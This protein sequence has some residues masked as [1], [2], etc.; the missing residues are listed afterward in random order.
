MRH[1]FSLSSVVVCAATGQ[2]RSSRM[3]QMGHVHGAVLCFLHILCSKIPLRGVEDFMQLRFG[4]SMRL[5]LRGQLLSRRI[6]GVNG[7][8][9]PLVLGAQLGRHTESHHLHARQQP[10]SGYDHSLHD[11]FV[12]TIFR[13]SPV[14]RLPLVGIGGGAHHLPQGVHL[15]RQG[16]FKELIPASPRRRR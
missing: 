7:F 4:Q 15:H 10:C 1:A 3:D 12:G 2:A 13:G 9:H 8:V 5:Q 14:R 16:S 11:V 6:H